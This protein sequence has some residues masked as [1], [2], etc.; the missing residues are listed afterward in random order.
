MIVIYIDKDGR[1]VFGAYSGGIK[2]VASP[3]GVNY[4]DGHWHHVVATMSP[5]GAA[6]YLDGNQVDSNPSMTA[7]QRIFSGGY[8]KVGCGKVT[9]WKNADGSEYHGPKYFSGSMQY[10][11]VYTTALTEHQVRD[12]YLAGAP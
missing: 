4:S 10:S 6:L 1:V 7:G 3:A 9:Y 8:W 11:S 5:N 2:L 12:H